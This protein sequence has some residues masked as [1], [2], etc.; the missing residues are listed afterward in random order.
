MSDSVE[1]LPDADAEPSE[2]LAHIIPALWRSLTRATQAAQELP[3]LESQVSILRK[4]DSYGPMSPAQLADELHL[5]RPTVSNLLKELA[6]SE[7]VE[8]Q[9][10]EHDGRSVFILLT[11][12]GQSVL[13]T[14]RRDRAAILQDAIAALADEDR[15]KIVA[16]VT[17]LRGLI[18][19]LGLIAEGTTDAADRRQTA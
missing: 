2:Q 13:S 18:L 1:F 15:A 8:R 12:H 3:A 4:L 10:S 16:A 6:R 17:S 5:A 7:M 19:E 14:F 11:P 9:P